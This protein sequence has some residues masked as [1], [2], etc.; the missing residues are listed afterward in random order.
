[1]YLGYRGCE[2]Q[3]LIHRRSFFFYSN[4]S[5]SISPRAYR[6][7]RISMADSFGGP[8]SRDGHMSPKN[9]VNISTTIRIPGSNFWRP[10]D[11][12]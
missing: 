10:I 12:M 7:L 3:G 11:L 2:L 8:E 5:S 9:V 6:F 1:M 4:S